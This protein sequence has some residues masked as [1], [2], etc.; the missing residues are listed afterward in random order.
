MCKHKNKLMWQYHT[1]TYNTYKRDLQAWPRR[2]PGDANYASMAALS[3]SARA[4]PIKPLKLKLVRSPFW[5]LWQKERGQVA[6]TA[7]GEVIHLYSNHLAQSTGT[8]SDIYIYVMAPFP[9]ANLFQK[10]LILFETGQHLL[11]QV[12]YTRR[13]AADVKSLLSL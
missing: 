4:S 6:D 11:M 8:I 1:I 2:T 5:D 12:E 13:C 10:Q 9:T 3:R 7:W